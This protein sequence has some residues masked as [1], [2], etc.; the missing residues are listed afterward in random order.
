MAFPQVVES[1]YFSIPSKVIDYQQLNFIGSF[2]K[3]LDRW[4][5]SLL[6]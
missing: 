4:S 6:H 2:V 1:N 5:D 3:S